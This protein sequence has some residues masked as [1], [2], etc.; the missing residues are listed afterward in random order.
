MVPY[1]SRWLGVVLWLLL[2]PAAPAEAPRTMRLDFYHTGNTRQ[3]LYSL[4][5]VVVEPLPWPGNPE[6]PVEE[7]DLG[8]YRF[9]VSDPKSNKVLFARG[10][11]SIY[12]EWVTTAEARTANRTFHESLRFPR[13]DAPVRVVVRQ[14]DADNR[15]RE[16]WALTVDPKDRNVDTS[17]TDAPCPLVE[18]EKNGDP[19]SHVDLLFLGDGYTADEQKKFEADARRV[20]GR[21]FA[22]SPYK[23]R[24]KDFNVWGLC[25]PARKSGVSRPSA[26]IHRASPLGTSYDTFGLSRYVLTFDNKAVRS[27]AAFAPYDCLVILVN[28]RDYGGGGIFRLYSTLA[29]DSAWAPYLLIHE[30]GH[31]FAGLA[32]EYYTAQVSY[33]PANKRVEP[34]EPNVTALLDP[35]KLKWKDMVGE[36]TP[37]PTPWQKAEYEKQSREN[38]ARREKLWKEGR[39]AAEVEAFSK[40]TQAQE[41]RLL[42]AERFAGK[43]G[44][45]EGANY[46][47]AGF[48]RPEANCVMFTQTEHFCEVCRRALDRMIDFHTRP[49]RAK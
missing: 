49:A 47:A 26:G 13:S 41:Q 7:A 32:D 43:V 2:V 9:E 5:R 19:A 11:D 20:V 35:A 29:A 34:W 28:G 12:G 8:R 45:F 38:Q 6:Q 48:Y 25:P 37:I 44:A 17:E 46:A 24:R 10:F 42:A 23:D 14:R 1:R 22:V 30:F 4:D 33:L 16:A 31:H 40:E 39:P 21:L 3:E 18:I 36:G 27:V 15:W